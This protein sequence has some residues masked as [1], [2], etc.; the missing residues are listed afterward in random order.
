MPGVNRVSV[1]VVPDTKGFRETV[2]KFL[3]RLERTTALTVNLDID[4]AAARAKV[5]AF[6]SEMNR[7]DATLDVA[8][9]TGKASADMDV[10]DRDRKVQIKPEVD[11]ASLA[12]VNS[13]FAGI[14]GGNGR[15]SRGELWASVLT[16]LTPVLLSSTAGLITMGGALVSLAALAAPVPG[17]LMAGGAAAAV[18][19]IALKNAKTELASLNPLW[20]TLNA[21]IQKN[22]WGAAKQPILDLVKSIFPQ[23]KSSLASVSSALG[24]WSGSVAK[25]FQKAFGGNAITTIMGNL[26]DAIRNST[27]GTDAFAASIATLGK[28][29]A[30]YLP[31][32]GAWFS[33]ISD[34]FNAWVQR[35]ASDGTLQGWVSTAMRV[36]GQVGSVAKSTGRILKGLF[37]A[38]SAGGSSGL[39]TFAGALN[40]IAGIVNSPSF[41]KA[42][43]ALFSG[44]AAGASGLALALP[45]LGKLLGA[46]AKAV[47][48]VA[49]KLG[50]DIGKALDVLAPAI[51]KVLPKLVPLVVLLG[52]GLLKAVEK[53][54]PPLADFI[55][56]T[57]PGLT[58]TVKIALPPVLKFVDGVA[59]VVK[60]AAKLA[61]PLHAGAKAFQ[62]FAKGGNGLGQIMSDSLSGKFGNVLKDIKK[63]MDGLSQIMSDSLSGKF[64][65]LTQ[66]ITTFVYNGGGMLRDFFTNTTGMFADFFTNTLGMFSD[67]FVNLPQGIQQGL[68]NVISGMLAGLNTGFA[69]LGG[70]LASLHANFLSYLVG[71][72]T[73]L[74]QT[75]T[76]IINGMAAGIGI[77]FALLGGWLIALPGRILAFLVSAG[78]WLV[79]TGINLIGGMANGVA[80]GFGMVSSFLVSLPARIFS[81]V[82]GAGAWLVS[83]G[84]RL[85]GGMANG[86]QAGSGSLWSFIG[87]LPGRILGAFAGAGSWLV[88]SGKAIIQ[89]FIDGIRSMMGAVSNAVG[90]VMNFVAGFFPHS[91]AERGPFSGSGWTAVESAGVAIGDQFN[92]G[93]AAANLN[94][95]LGVTALTGSNAG[96]T[97]GSGGPLIENATFVAPDQ[98]PIVSG[99]IM[100]REFQRVIGGTV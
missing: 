44:A 76:D 3:Q 42:L 1:R 36:L 32:I 75:G 56:N 27:K 95:P 85:L 86:A 81:F 9:D 82:A 21:T 87:S 43:S 22:F 93:L 30:S 72:V 40:T 57:L 52:T 69:L 33:D 14:G 67:F 97:A 2:Q 5:D 37:D 80:V 74:V 53:L 61:E 60:W 26:S 79:Q 70:W 84:I 64:G 45:G 7:K 77:G 47:D 62:D 68:A 10:L 16:P 91:P 88:S 78:T 25:S 20:K 39:Q 28:F 31:K 38:A 73:W 41:Q 4:T 19:V 48:D 17:L 50:P 51:A 98:N 11:K 59:A 65:D 13:A 15:M 24:T 71:A 46:L 55:T 94:V 66:S 90:G 34:K 18:F 29:G 49:A 12:K 35:L 58:E 6:A 96:V 54:A 100:A 89:G 83:A 23:L 63:G 8:A 92:K 99:R